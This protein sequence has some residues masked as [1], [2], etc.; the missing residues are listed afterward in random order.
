[1][2][3]HNYDLNISVNELFKYYICKYFQKTY[4]NVC[5]NITIVFI[6][7]DFM[8]FMIKVIVLF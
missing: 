3:S 8:N 5:Y 4:C 1:M 6:V 7:Y 2:F